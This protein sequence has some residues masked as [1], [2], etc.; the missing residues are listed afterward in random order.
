MVGNFGVSF[1][2][3]LRMVGVVVVFVV[4][5]VSVVVD[6]VDVVV[7]VGV[8]WIRRVMRR[9]RRIRRR[10]FLFSTLYYSSGRRIIR[11]RSLSWR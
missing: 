7:V 3:V 10:M 6:A 9:E 2:F 1:W 5:V 4:V 8:L 11:I